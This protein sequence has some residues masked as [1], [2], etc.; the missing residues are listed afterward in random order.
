VEDFEERNRTD[1][2]EQQMRRD[3]TER[4]ASERKMCKRRLLTTADP[5][6]NLRMIQKV[7][8]TTVSTIEGH[9]SYREA[10]IVLSSIRPLG[11]R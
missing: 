5:F 4:P 7:R 3:E 1:E 10:S 8:I 11:L 9:R 6:L 2:I